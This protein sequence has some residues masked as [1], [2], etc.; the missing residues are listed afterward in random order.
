MEM[1]SQTAVGHKN[2]ATKLDPIQRS[3]HLDLWLIRSPTI[4]NNK[5]NKKNEN[6]YFA[7]V[8]TIVLV[9]RK[10]NVKTHSFE[11]F[12]RE[13]GIKIRIE[14]QNTRSRKKLFFL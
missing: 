4:I 11:L 5:L 13:I 10:K 1:T 14:K 2:T 7:I 9:Q 3:D 12:S 8:K 6:E